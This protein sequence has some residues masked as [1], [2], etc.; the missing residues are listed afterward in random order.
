MP[1]VYLFRGKV[2][3]GARFSKAP[4]TSR[5]RKAI[6]NR[7]YLKN[8]EVYRPETLYEGNLCSC[9]KYH[10]IKQLCNYKV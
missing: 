8:R 10:G 4:K 9:E 6:L 2:S 7:L 1:V 5:N 3:P